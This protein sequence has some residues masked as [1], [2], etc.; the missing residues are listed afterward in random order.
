MTASCSRQGNEIKYADTRLPKTVGDNQ[1][2]P[3]V[4]DHSA[5]PDKVTSFFSSKTTYYLS[6]D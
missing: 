1:V 2:K 3:N 4:C 6:K 5:L